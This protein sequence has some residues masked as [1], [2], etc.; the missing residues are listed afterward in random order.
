MFKE[1]GSSFQ[2]S[3]ALYDLVF[4]DPQL[5]WSSPYAMNLPNYRESQKMQSYKSEVYA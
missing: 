1:V 3:F 2:V 4:S 5:P